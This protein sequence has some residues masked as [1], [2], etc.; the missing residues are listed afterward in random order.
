[1]DLAW[2]VKLQGESISSMQPRLVFR[3]Q[4]GQIWKSW[5]PET[6]P[7]VL[8]IIMNPIFLIT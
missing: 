3:P 2:H 4:K 1:M 7:E 8:H 6:I 5:L